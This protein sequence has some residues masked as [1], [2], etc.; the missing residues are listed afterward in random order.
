MFSPP[1]PLKE[2]AVSKLYAVS[3]AVISSILCYDPQLPGWV[4]DI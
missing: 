3:V 2:V 1:P 4:L